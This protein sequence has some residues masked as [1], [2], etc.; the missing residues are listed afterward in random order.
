M[1]TKQSIRFK[2]KTLFE[3]NTTSKLDSMSQDIER[4][5]LSLDQFKSAKTIAAYYPTSFEPDIKRVLQHSIDTG[6]S[7]CLPYS[8]NSGAYCLKEL[9]SLETLQKGAFGILQPT[10]E[11]REIDKRKIDLWLV[12]GVS[13]TKTGIRLGHGKGIYDRLLLNS[14]GFKVG[15]CFD[16]QVLKDLPEDDWD[17]NLDL[18]CF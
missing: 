18:V 6:K 13:F 5:L 10:D 8:S 9:S 2:I 15:L 1:D 7:V 12:P 11:A 3:S 4:T 14:T 16:F 17:I